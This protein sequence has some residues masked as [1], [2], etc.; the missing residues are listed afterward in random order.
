M[1]HKGYSIL[2]MLLALE[3]G[4]ETARQNHEDTPE[5]YKIPGEWSVYMTMEITTIQVQL[6]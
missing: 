1:R 4:M 5:Q 6:L 3:A 2:W